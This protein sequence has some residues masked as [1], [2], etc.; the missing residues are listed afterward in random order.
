MVVKLKTV[1]EAATEL[2]TVSKDALQ[3]DY[4]DVSSLVEYGS[5]PRKNDAQVPRM[6]EL[7]KAFGFKVPIL[8]RG[9]RIVDG[10][11]RIKAARSMGMTQVPVI[12]VGNMPDAHERALRIAINKSVDWAEWDTDLLG[13]EMKAIMGDGLNLSLTG[14][15][16]LEI[17][18]LVKTPVPEPFD[19]APKV[20]KTKDAD[21]GLPPDPLS[22]S[23]SFTLSDKNRTRVLT[24]LEAYREKN[25]L[26][27]H[28][29]ALL[30]MVVKWAE[31]EGVSLS[32]D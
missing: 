25:S 7:I 18:K 14:F 32:K 19:L 13:K 28:S 20:T 22:V 2:A 31:A 29:Q 24:G 26:T 15:S 8:V 23:M 5:N 12:D 17:G 16:S 10:H 3:L 21:A 9:N 27:N 30:A 1:P 11:L 6:V 4:R